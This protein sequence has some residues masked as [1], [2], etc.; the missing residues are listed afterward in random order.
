[1]LMGKSRVKDLRSPQRSQN[2]TKI[3]AALLRCNRA[4]VSNASA[5]NT[6]R[7]LTNSTGISKEVVVGRNFLPSLSSTSTS[8]VHRYAS[9]TSYNLHYHKPPDGVGQPSSTSI[10]VHALYQEQ[11]KEIQSEREAIFGKESENASTD[12]SPGDLSQTA[13][14]YFETDGKDTSSEPF[15]RLP[16]GWNAKEEE[17]L[18]VSKKD[19]DGTFPQQQSSPGGFLSSSPSSSSPPG[20]WNAQELEEAYA[21]RE[22]IY[23]FSDEEKSAWSLH[24]NTDTL[25]ASHMHKI[26][27]MIR[28]EAP[29]SSHDHNHDHTF[30]TSDPTQHHPTSKSSSASQFSHLTP[31]GDGVSMVDVGNKVSTRRVAIAR[32]VV[33]FPPEVLSAFQ[34]STSNNE[35]V[36]PKGPIFETAKIAGIMGAK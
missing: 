14:S 25:S 12:D 5:S 31:K 23:A 36:G 33:V 19:S 9:S 27:E 17:A 10:D 6:L 13:K 22:A 15:L 30:E 29:S 35:M 28:G 18:H 4:A 16:P 8:Y 11:M 21:E 3:M 24:N 7:R 20:P 34:V 32:S 26:R 2:K 1:M